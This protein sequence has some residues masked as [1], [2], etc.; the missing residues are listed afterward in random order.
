MGRAYEEMF[1]MLFG[2]GGF[3]GNR[4]RLSQRS[5]RRPYDDSVAPDRTRRQCS[6]LW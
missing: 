6:S 2:A 4:Y 3:E 1:L 5:R